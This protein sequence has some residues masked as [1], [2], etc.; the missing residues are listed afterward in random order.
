MKQLF[1]TVCENSKLVGVNSYVWYRGKI[2]EDLYFGYSNLETAKHV[3]PNTI[4]RIAS[5]SKVIVAL[6]IM[7][8]YEEGDLS[9]DEDISRY[10]GFLVRNPKFKDKKITIKMLMTQTSSIT[11][12]Q[13]K[14]VNSERN[15]GYNKVNGTNDSV[16]LKDLLVEGSREWTAD[17][18]SN[19]EPGKHFEYSNFG[20]GILACIIEKITGQY[21]TEYVKDIIF[22]PMMLDASFVPSDIISTDISST[23]KAVGEDTVLNRTRESF[24]KYEYKKFPLGD[25]YRGPAGGL[26]ISIKSLMR[27]LTSLM[28]DDEQI[29]SKDTFDLMMSLTWYGPKMNYSSYSAKGLQ[30]EI[31]DYFDNRRLYGHFGDAYGVKSFILFNK[32]EQ[33]AMVYVANGGH[34]KYQ[35][36]G[37]ADIHEQVIKGALDKYWKNKIHCFSFDL[38]SHFGDVDGR[39]VYIDYKI[40]NGKIHFPLLTMLDVLSINTSLD[41]EQT[42]EDYQDRCFDDILDILRIDNDVCV[43]ED[44]PKYRINYVAKQ[45]KPNPLYHYLKCPTCFKRLVKNNQQYECVNFHN[46]DIASE[47]YINLLLNQPNS[48]DNK[49]MVDARIN[50]LKAGH[51]NPLAKTLFKFLSN[52]GVSTL[53]DVGCG[54]GYYDRKIKA[55]FP[56]FQMAGIDISKYATLMA[57]KSQREIFYA[58]A[59]AYNMPFEDESYDLILNVFAPACADEFVRVAKKYILKVIPGPRHLMELKKLLYDDVTSNEKEDLEFPGFIKVNQENLNFGARVNE[60]EDLVKMTPY[61][62]SGQHK[63]DLGQYSYLNVT[64]DFKI[65]LYK[66]I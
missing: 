11:D 12:G 10:L 38:T 49:M 18:F 24:L 65:I 54:D 25:N 6:C 23:Y 37:I 7:R 48:G 53:L 20:C 19:Y 5:V 3:S 59:S 27:I 46:F 9:L 8:L 28:I 4:Y 43:K 57:A 17:T 13:E 63:D 30:L 39:R 35:E 44:G 29:I 14:D 61:Y 21:F 16:S 31:L 42:I 52:L 58:V 50:F 32:H 41:Y 22:R 47:G 34:Y 56:S 66:K 64:C 51:F 15:T 2:V 26:F 60:V 45:E 40:K 33:F 36:C 62:Y 55:M 1:K